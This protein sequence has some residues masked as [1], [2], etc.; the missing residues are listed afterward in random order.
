MVSQVLRGEIVKTIQKEENWSLVNTS[1]GY[2]GF[3]RTNHIGQVKS[4]PP[5][6]LPFQVISSSIECLQDGTQVPFLKGSFIWPEI[7]S[8][9]STISFSAGQLKSLPENPVFEPRHFVKTALDCINIPYFWGGRSEWGMD[10][11]GLVQFCLNFLG[12]EFPRDAWQ[13]AEQPGMEIITGSIADILPGDLLFFQ[14]GNNKI[15]HVAISL[16]KGEY[17]HASEWVRINSLDPVSESFD[18]ERK[19][20][21]IGSLRL[22]KDH[23]TSRA[24]SIRA[25]INS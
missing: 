12:F 14:R 11:S 17:V 8:D 24:D 4:L 7:N 10:C 2:S 22:S 23:L 19:D 9:F 15:H 20:T 1:D 25:L 18:A 16:G 5:N 21:W 6:Q 13:Q 3:I